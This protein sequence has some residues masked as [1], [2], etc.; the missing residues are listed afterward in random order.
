MPQAEIDVD[1]RSRGW[2]LPALVGGAVLAAEVVLRVLALIGG[3]I[4]FF[5]YVARFNTWLHDIGI[6]LPPS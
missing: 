2:N 6:A 1:E 4:Q 5:E 3:N